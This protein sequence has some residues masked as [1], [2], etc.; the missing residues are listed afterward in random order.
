VVIHP[1]TDSLEKQ[2]R[3]LFYSVSL[4]LHVLILL[5]FAGANRWGWLDRPVVIPPPEAEP[6]VFDLTEPRRPTEVI[7]TPADA[8]P[9]ENPEDARFLSDQSV[10]ARN[11]Q[12]AAVDLLDR[13]H[14]EGAIDSR[15]L[16]PRVEDEPQDPSRSPSDSPDTS[17]RLSD[18][19]VFD[20]SKPLSEDVV[21]RR[22][23]PDDPARPSTPPGVPHDARDSRVPETGG[24]SFNTY[25]W[26]YAPYMLMLKER[27]RR[28]IFPPLAFTRL[29]AING[30]NFLKFRIYPDGRME[31]LTLLG[32]QGDRSLARTSVNAVDASAPFPPLPDDFPEPFLEITGKF[33]YFILR[34][35]QEN[36]K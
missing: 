11:R 4:G 8:Q 9:L 10:R 14:A 7:E 36:P 20:P 24:L 5:F 19:L 25:A 13:P 26:N 21:P 34:S 33:V 17:R 35:D 15:D 18:Y 28:N 3:I 22:P 6:I 1:G 16:A 2:Q 32:Y 30:V 29:G 23:A 31:G 27:I 12:D